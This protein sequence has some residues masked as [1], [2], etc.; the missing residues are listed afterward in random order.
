MEQFLTAESPAFGD[1]DT[2]KA[3]IEESNVRLECFKHYLIL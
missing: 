1:R 3:Q 2:L